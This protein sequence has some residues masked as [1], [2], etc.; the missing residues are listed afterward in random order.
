MSTSRETAGRLAA[1]ISDIVSSR[2]G[3][4][5]PPE[6]N[7]ANIADFWRTWVKTKHGVDLKFDR[8][9][10]GAM[11]ALIKIARLGQTPSHEDSALDGAIYL[12]LGHG[13]VPADQADAKPEVVMA[14]KA[15][16]SAFT[17]EIARLAEWAERHGLP[18]EAL[19]HGGM[20]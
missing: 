1:Q 18:S 8:A 11:S 15:D 19:L 3:N 10:V 14:F 9:D 4:Y 6:D 5:G 13:C 12:M 7:F 20:A 16:V 2:G 17:A